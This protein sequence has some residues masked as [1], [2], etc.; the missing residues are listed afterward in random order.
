MN[1]TE[2]RALVAR[3]QNLPGDTLVGT[4][5]SKVPEVVSLVESAELT[6]TTEGPVLN[7]VYRR[8][9]AEATN[10]GETL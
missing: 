8:E 7:L 3:T 2:L 9:T 1:L 4:S 5:F 10:E 6:Q